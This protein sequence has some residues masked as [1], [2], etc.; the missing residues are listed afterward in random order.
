[1]TRDSLLLSLDPDATGDLQN[2]QSLTYVVCTVERITITVRYH[3][4]YGR[5][6]E[7]RPRTILGRTSFG[8]HSSNCLGGLLRYVN[9]NRGA[10]ELGD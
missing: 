10:D 7:T 1:M 5:S 9:P 3:F 6:L 8:R 2:E 4:E